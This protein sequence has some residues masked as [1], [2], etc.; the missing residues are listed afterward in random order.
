MVIEVYLDDG[1]IYKYEVASADKAREHCAAIVATGY[2]HNNGD[3]V[4]EHYP[5]HRILKVK[6]VGAP[7]PTRY[8]D[9]SSGT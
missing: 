1:R 7:V 8:K 4:F 2:R 5:A 6:A 3:G 9:E